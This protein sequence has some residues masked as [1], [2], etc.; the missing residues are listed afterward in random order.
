MQ[1]KQQA[2]KISHRNI[3][4]RQDPDL[5]AAFDFWVRSIYLDR[6]S[7][8]RETSCESVSNNEEQPEQNEK[9]HAK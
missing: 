5:K 6:P 3:E 2:V 1:T 9:T 8:S 4:I 7:P